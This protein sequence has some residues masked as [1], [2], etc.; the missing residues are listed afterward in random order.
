M[1]F[2]AYLDKLPVEDRP[3]VIVL[4]CVANLGANRAIEGRT[5]KGTKLVVDALRERCYEGEWRNISA[6]R[7]CLPH[8][9]PRVWGSS[10]N[11][12]EGL[13]LKHRNLPASA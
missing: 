10:S 2:L 5:E 11:Y 12:M 6:T 3:K 9:R 4:E 8:S 1:P 7:F 13:G